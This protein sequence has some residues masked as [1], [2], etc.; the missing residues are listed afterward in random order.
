[1]NN[2]VVVMMYFAL[3]AVSAGSGPNALAY[4]RADEEAINKEIRVEKSVATEA[5]VAKEAKAEERAK[6]KVEEEQ[7]KGEGQFKLKF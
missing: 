4:E 2:S 3:F 1:M 7:S 5:K 6:K